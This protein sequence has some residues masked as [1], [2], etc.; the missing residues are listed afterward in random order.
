VSTGFRLLGAGAAASF[1]GKL[2]P[3]QPLIEFVSVFSRR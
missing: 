3:C 1:S 2:V